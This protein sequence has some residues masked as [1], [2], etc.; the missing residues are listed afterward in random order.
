MKLKEPFF[1]FHFF[2]KA[3]LAHSYSFLVGVHVVVFFK[4][5]VVSEANEIHMEDLIHILLAQS[6]DLM[7]D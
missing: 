1:F 2:P 4:E 3:E 7:I 6:T 5:I